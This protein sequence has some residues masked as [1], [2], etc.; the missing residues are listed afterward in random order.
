MTLSRTDPFIFAAN[1]ETQ[2][3]YDNQGNL[4]NTLYAD[5]YSVTSAYNLLQQ[6][7]RTSDSGGNNVT[8]TYNNQGLLT[9]VSNALGRVQS[10]AYDILDRAT[11]S[12][13]ANG[14][15]VAATY[16]NLNRP[17][18]R[19]YPDGGVEHYPRPVSPIG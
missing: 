6:V 11:N 14:V 17:L 10:A 1:N 2:F 8:N 4:T 13:D 18:A 5:G 7:A 19:G 3:F 12:V 15:S 9:T 16:D